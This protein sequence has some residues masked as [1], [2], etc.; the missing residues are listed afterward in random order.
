[1][2]I[3]TLLNRLDKVKRTARDKWQAS[4]PAHDD[5]R[6]SLA[7]RE[8]ED[9]RI[10]IHCFSGCGVDEILNATGLEIDALFPPQ[11]LNHH[12]AKVRKPW[13]AS[14]ILHALAFEILVA[15]QYTNVLASG[16][17]LSEADRTRLVLCA[18]RLQSG[19]KVLNG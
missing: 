6:P 19:L 9:G 8:L 11:P 4:C 1:M 16:Q 2:T 10:L 17:A 13:N 18:S 14:D 12:Q 15:L 7:I 3:D 5:K